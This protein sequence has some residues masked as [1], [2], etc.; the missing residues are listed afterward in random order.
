MKTRIILASLFSLVISFSF[1]QEIPPG[2]IPGFP[3]DNS[4]C[5]PIAWCHP[6]GAGMSLMSDSDVSD[7]NDALED[8]DGCYGACTLGKWFFD[9]IEPFYPD[10]Y[11]NCNLEGDGESESTQSHVNDAPPLA[12]RGTI[13]AKTFDYF[14]TTLPNKFKNRAGRTAVFKGLEG[15]KLK[16]GGMWVYNEKKMDEF[17]VLSLEP[18]DL[19]SGESYDRLYLTFTK[20][21]MVILNQS[22][23]NNMKSKK[24]G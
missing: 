17:H 5:P 2:G 7:I 20:K 8:P 10:C 1:A 6:D 14:K 13:S 11:P 21:S 22:W 4:G 3:P 19:K 18:V 16:L 24:K 15:T 23:I 12:A 9:L